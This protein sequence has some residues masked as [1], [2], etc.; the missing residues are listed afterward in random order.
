MENGGSYRY[1]YFIDHC[2]STKRNTSA[3]VKSFVGTSEYAL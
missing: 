2:K 1:G 3:V